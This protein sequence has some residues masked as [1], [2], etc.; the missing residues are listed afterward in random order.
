MTLLESD[1][2]STTTAGL[3]PTPRPVLAPTQAPTSELGLGLGGLGLG[4]GGVGLGIKALLK[5]MDLWWD[6]DA[7]F[8]AVSLGGSM[9]VY[10]G[11]SICGEGHPLVPFTLP[12]IKMDLESGGWG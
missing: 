3:K 2:T 8:V 12:A 6:L 11:D 10:V 1:E 7:S 9:C 4:L 5:K